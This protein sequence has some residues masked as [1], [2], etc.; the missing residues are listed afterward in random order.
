MDCLSMF[1]VMLGL[2]L[3]KLNVLDIFKIVWVLSTVAQEMFA[4]Y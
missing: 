1:D 4:G 3:R 2:G